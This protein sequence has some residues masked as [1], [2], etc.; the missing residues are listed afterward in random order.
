MSIVF[1][2]SMKEPQVIRRSLFLERLFY[3]WTYLL[4]YLFV[5]IYLFFNHHPIFTNIF[6]SILVFSFLTLYTLVIRMRQDG[7]ILLKCLPKYL[8]KNCMYL[9]GNVHISIQILIIK[10]SMWCFCHSLIIHPGTS[11]SKHF[12]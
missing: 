5:N 6:F 1:G 3:W 12:Q 4:L 7:L 9:I 11:G 2:T 8:Q 10:L